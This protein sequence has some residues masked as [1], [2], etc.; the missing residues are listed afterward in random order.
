MARKKEISISG[1][2][3][4]PGRN[5]PGTVIIT[6]PRLFMKDMADYM[7]A[8]RGGEQCGL[9]TADEAV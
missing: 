5:T 1:N 7:Q 9:H 2:M 3:P 6:A 4:L 8:V